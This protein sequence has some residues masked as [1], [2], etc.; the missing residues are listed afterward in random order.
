VGR[1]AARATGAHA[2][3]DS[4]LDLKEG[5]FQEEHR[6][7]RKKT[8]QTQRFALRGRARKATS[9]W[10]WDKGGLQSWGIRH[11]SKG[12]GVLKGA[13]REESRPRGCGQR[14]LDDSAAR[15]SAPRMYASDET[16]RI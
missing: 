5:I 4:N 1:T 15:Y 12:V 7:E 9:K 14:G 13:A 10:K 8:Q 2:H 16:L 11:Q 3:A 6:S